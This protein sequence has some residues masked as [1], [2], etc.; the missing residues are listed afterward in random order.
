MADVLYGIPP[1]YYATDLGHSLGLR[2]VGEGIETIGQLRLLQQ[3]GCDEGQGYL[4]AKPLPSAE[5]RSLLV[6]ERGFSMMTAV[7]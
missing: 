2:V 4:F 7:L 1:G 5:F 6:A 3:L